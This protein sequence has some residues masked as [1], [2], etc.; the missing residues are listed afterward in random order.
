M[1]YD[2][3]PCKK[4]K[5]GCTDRHTER[6]EDAETQAE[7]SLEQ[8]DAGNRDLLHCPPALPTSGLQASSFQAV[9]QYICPKPSRSQYFVIAALA[10]DFLI[11]KEIITDVQSLA[12]SDIAVRKESSRVYI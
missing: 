3:C 12:K 7:D 5:F 10:N 8:E 1:Q 4:R 2:C 11:V 6:E 9:R